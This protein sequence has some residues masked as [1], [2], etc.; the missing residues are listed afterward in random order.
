MEALIA[1]MK[2]SGSSQNSKMTYSKLCPKTNFFLYSSVNNMDKL[3]ESL[4]SKI[5]SLVPS[6]F[7]SCAWNQC[8]KESNC[9]NFC[10]QNFC[11][12][13]NCKIVRS[14][15]KCSNETGIL[16]SLGRSVV[17]C[18]SGD[19]D[20]GNAVYC[21]E[22]VS[23]GA[24][25][26]EMTGELTVG[27]PR[28]NDRLYLYEM[29]LDHQIYGVKQLFLNSSRMGNH[30][31]FVNG[32]CVP[33]AEYQNWT[34]ERGLHCLVVSTAHIFSGMNVTVNY[35]SSY[36]YGRECACGSLQCSSQV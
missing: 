1:D 26:I 16:E 15:G 31:R 9:I 13:N 25:L 24:R 34:S 28:T 22:H 32:R 8:N 35:G 23:S 36:S 20:L 33:N 14:G 21:V 29:K 3:T 10:A 2:S 30:G 6:T 4:R 18:W 11:N 27:K 5:L 19:E 17:A 12:A 7:C